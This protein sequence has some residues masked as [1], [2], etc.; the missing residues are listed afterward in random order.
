MNFM[1]NLSG[2]VAPIVAGIVADRLGFAPNFIITSCILVVGLLC[3]L[4]LLGKIEQIQ[5]TESHIVTETPEY[6]SANRRKAS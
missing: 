1:G 5:A 2:I 6:V 4:L 3:F